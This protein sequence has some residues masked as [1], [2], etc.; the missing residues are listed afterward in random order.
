MRKAHTAAHDA[1]HAAEAQNA[2]LL[3][4]AASAST[5]SLDEAAERRDGEAAERHAGEARGLMRQRTG[6]VLAAA[7]DEQRDAAATLVQ[8]RIH[9]NTTR[10]ALANREDANT[11]I[12]IRGR[13]TDWGQA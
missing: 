6:G 9:G 10:R 8:A 1:V 13:P 3:G 12:P 11:Q 4:R 2:Q 7:S 5:R